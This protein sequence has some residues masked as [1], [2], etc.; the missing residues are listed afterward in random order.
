MRLTKQQQR[1]ILAGML[2]EARRLTALGVDMREVAHCVRQVRDDL[3]SA[4][5]QG[6]TVIAPVEE[7]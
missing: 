7:Q 1:D 2:A 5:R 4:L 3:R 6:V